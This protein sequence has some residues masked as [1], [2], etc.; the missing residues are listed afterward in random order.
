MRFGVSTWVWV[1]PLTDEALQQLVPQVADAG[2]DWIELP[3]ETPGAFDYL[4]ASELVR[5]HDLGV[6]VCAVMSPGRD[7]LD[8]DAGVRR[9]SADYVR[10]CVN[11]AETLGAQ[12]VIGPLYASTGLVWQAGAEERKRDLSLLADELRELAEYAAARQ[13]V[14]CVEPLNRFE[15]SFLN[16]ASQGVELIDRVA[17]PGCQL[18]LD[19]FHMN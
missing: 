15:T 12:H 17:H 16:L 7:L 3:V 19:T 6:G 1:A 8:P 11:V 13:V 9:A 18:M 4:R 2:F 10:H 14:L 5:R